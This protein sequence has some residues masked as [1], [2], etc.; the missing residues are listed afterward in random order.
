MRRADFVGNIINAI[1]LLALPR[2]PREHKAELNTVPA[3]NKSPMHVS[4]GMEKPLPAVV[5]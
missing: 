4:L 2:G 1:N 5:T 3:Q